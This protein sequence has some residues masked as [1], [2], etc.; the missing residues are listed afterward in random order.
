M[1][2]LAF[3]N[4]KSTPKFA[5]FVRYLCDR[6]LIGFFSFLFGHVEVFLPWSVRPR[7]RERLLESGAY[8]LNCDMI[9]LETFEIVAL[10]FIWTFHGPYHCIPWSYHCI[11]WSYHCIPWLLPLYSMVPTY[12]QLSF[13]KR[14]PWKSA[15]AERQPSLKEWKWK[16]VF[17]T[18]T[19]IFPL[20]AY[21]LGSLKILLCYLLGSFLLPKSISLALFCSSRVSPWSFFAPQEYFLGSFHIQLK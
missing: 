17:H 15:S 14:A 18:V 13:Y 2:L 1:V 8:S 6:S 10:I 9:F 20:C 3:F 19:L 21:G 4:T 11:P 7:Q 12:H 5:F 16:Y